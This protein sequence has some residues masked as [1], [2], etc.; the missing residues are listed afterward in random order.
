MFPL[1][2]D[3]GLYRT[4]SFVEEFPTADDFLDFYK[5][6]EG[7]PTTISD[8]SAK[9]LYYLLYARYGD[10]HIAMSSYQRFKYAVMATIYKYGPTWEKRLDIQEKIRVLTLD[11]LQEGTLAVT[12]QAKNPGNKLEKDDDLIKNVNDQSRTK[13]K[14]SKL[15]AY[16]QLYMLLRTDVTEEFLDKF[17]KLFNK[18]GDPTDMLG[19]YI[20]E[21]F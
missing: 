5:N 21:E 1:E 4:N 13:Y 8:N 19:Y 20:K 9:T 15:A 10:C 2:S 12:N 3:Y 14:K 11:D 7:I 17:K 16:E 18:F 6:N